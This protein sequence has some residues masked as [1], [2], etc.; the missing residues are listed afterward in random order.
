M[1]MT[2]K[3]GSRAVAKDPKALMARFDEIAI[4]VVRRFS[5]GNVAMQ[6][7]RILT[8]AELERQRKERWG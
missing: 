4:G 2:I 3:K 8:E 7:G 5:R 6:K 1:S